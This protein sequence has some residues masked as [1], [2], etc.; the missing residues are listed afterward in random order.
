MHGKRQRRSGAPAA[1]PCRGV[2]V[3]IANWMEGF[4]GEGLNQLLPTPTPW[5]CVTLIVMWVA[6]KRGWEK[7]VHSE[8]E[9]P[10]S[11]ENQNSSKAHLKCVTSIFQSLFI[12]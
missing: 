9:R 3:L 1:V 2:S 4:L 12:I 6:S 8:G 5:C 7:S 11:L 10:S